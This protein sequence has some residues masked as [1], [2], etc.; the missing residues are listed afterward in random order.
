MADP[1]LIASG[2][3]IDSTQLADVQF[4]SKSTQG[5]DKAQLNTMLARFFMTLLPF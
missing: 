5:V 1:R 3:I 4:E 2:N